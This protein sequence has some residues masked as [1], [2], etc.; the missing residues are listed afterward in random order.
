MKPFLYQIADLFHKNYGV[1]ISRFAFIFPNKRTGL[2]FQKYLSEIYDK[3]LFSPSI[4]AISDLF[5]ELSDKQLADRIGMLFKLY[6]IYIRKSNSPESF[7]E[8]LHWGEMLLSDFDDVDKYMANARMLFTNVTDLRTIES[9]YSFLSPSQIAVIRT[10]WNSFNPTTSGTNE[11]SFLAAWEILYDLYTTFREELAEEGKGYEGMIYR[12][13][14]DRLASVEK[15]DFPWEKVVFVGLNA[16]SLVE[17]K[18]LGELQKAGIADFYWDYE[19]DM[20]KDPENRASY[21]VSRNR[22]L[23]PSL[24]EWP[25]QQLAKPEIEV[26]GIPSGIGQAKQVYTLLEEMHRNNQLNPEEAL[27]TAI[28]LPD[29]SLLIPVLNSIPEQIKHINVTMG[30]PLTGTPVTSLMEYVLALHKNLRYVDRQPMFYYRDVLAVLNHRYMMSANKEVVS[31]LI[32]D[33]TMF[34][35]IYIGKDELART[36]LMETIFRP[37]DQVEELSDYLLDVLE[38]LN[39]YMRLAAWQENPVEEADEDELSILNSQL[40]IRD[41]EQEFIFHYFV[42]VNRMKEV[43][44]ECGIEIRINTYFRLLNRITENIK[45]PFKGEPLSGLQI[46]GILETRALDFDRLIILSMNEGVFPVKESSNSFIPYNLRKGF[47]LPTYEHQ[48]SIWAYYFYRLLQRTSH[49]SLI[50]DTRSTGLLSGEK[51]RFIHQLHYHYNYPLQ[52]KLVVY[53][54]SSSKTT[55][56]QMIKTDQIQEALSAFYVGGERALSASAINTYLDCP[57]KFYFMVIENV[58]E[59]EEVTEAMES[60]VFG[61]ILHKVLEDL[62]AP[63]RGRTLMPDILKSIRK[64]EELLTE[65]IRRAFAEIFFKTETVRPLTGR[66]FLIGEMIRKYVKKVLERDA[67]WAPFRYIES[68]KRIKDIFTM[69][70]NRQIQLKGFI[71]RVDEVNDTVRIIDYKSGE[72]ISTFRDIQSLFNKEEKERP[73]AVMQVFM[74]AW[75][76]NRL[77]EGRNRLVQPEIYFMRRIFYDT[78]DPDI[79]Y[80]LDRMKKARVEA[81]VEYATDF[82]RE[83]R[84]CLD[85]IFNPE[86]P[87]TQTPTGKACMWCNFKE[88]CGV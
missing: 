25:E 13:V 72:G 78:F 80:R 50:Y 22:S 33:I 49:V 64:S 27:K 30:Y 63:Y 4:L 47:D 15:L 88:I 59:E 8:F 86:I 77:P 35:K 62:Y 68:E 11:K 31:A 53:N 6:S 5:L 70:D 17:E 40:S 20:V 38:Q 73:K 51:S 60:D 57:L 69:S 10:F 52:N 24:L 2:F 46:M 36:P 71:D 56:L 7:D 76:Y 1:K 85:E 18:L 66:N 84:N 48:D 81:F 45:I 23:F 26:I 29:E 44:K 82:E 42:T 41:L 34:N 39:F 28:V 75:M 14:I 21:F 3:P 37:V 9:D 16:L 83:M 54:V 19:S 58:Q 87:F 79:Y 67:R 65:T 43:M 61:S 12:E 55:A 74:Y 32:R